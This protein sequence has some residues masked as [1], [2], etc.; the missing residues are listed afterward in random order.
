[1]A[2]TSTALYQQQAGSSWATAW[3]QVTPNGVGPN[4]HDILNIV[5]EGG[6]ILLNI[7]YAGVVHN[8]ASGSTGSLTR[9]GQFFTTLTSGTT[10]QLFANAFDNPANLDIIQIINEGGNV[11]NYIDYTGTS[12]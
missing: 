4:D 8:P 9:L 1:M 2:P 11:V 7:D 6:G 5:D 3:P 12:H 10:A